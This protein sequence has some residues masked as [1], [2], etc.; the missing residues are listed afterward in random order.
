MVILTLIVA[1]PLCV[2]LFCVPMYLPGGTVVDLRLWHFL[3]IPTLIKNDWTDFLLKIS[4]LILNQYII[5][6]ILP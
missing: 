6:K 4:T 3:V 2:C 1:I 5:L